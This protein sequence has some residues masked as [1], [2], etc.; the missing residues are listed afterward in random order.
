MHEW[1][2]FLIFPFLIFSLLL[3]IGYL[4]LIFSTFN[5]VSHNM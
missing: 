1:S 3:Y 2:A 5:D 4:Q